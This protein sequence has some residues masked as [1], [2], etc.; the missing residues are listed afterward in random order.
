M[1][2]GVLG[3]GDVGRVLG[4]GLAGLGHDVKLGSRDPG[5]EKLTA[6]SKETGPKASTGTFAEAAEFGEIVILATL[7]TGTK[8]A[9]DLAGVKNLEDKVLIDATNPLD[10]S[11]MPPG[12]AVSGK[13]SAGEQV[14]RWVPGAHVVKAFNSVGNQHMVKPSFPGGPPDLFICGNDD[15]AKASVTG[16]GKELGWS[17]VDMGGLE[18]ARYLES[19]AMLWIL[20]YVKAQNGNHAFKLLKK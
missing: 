18:S 2:I 11:S 15:G 16:L 19:L 12:L 20:Y 9:L 13:D 1:R 14:Q 4:A 6:W 7:W 3:S 17:V 5:Q 10:F 8:S